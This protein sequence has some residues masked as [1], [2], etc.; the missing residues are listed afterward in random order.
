MSLF[1]CFSLY[2]ICTNKGYI[3]QF[4]ALSTW[5]SFLH[6]FLFIILFYAGQVH[7]YNKYN[8]LFFTVSIGSKSLFFVKLKISLYF[9]SKF[10]HFAP[11]FYILHKSLYAYQFKNTVTQY[12]L[13][14]L[15]AHPY[16]SFCY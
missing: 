6:S 13:F 12:T 3:F 14:S 2:I 1:Q 9:F 5:S 4:Y 11:I 16:K 8:C 15:H 7:L 10:L